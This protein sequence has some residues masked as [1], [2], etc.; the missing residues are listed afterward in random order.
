MIFNCIM[1][2]GFV[3]CFLFCV[4]NL[5]NDVTGQ[6]ADRR[7]SSSSQRSAISSSPQA[8]HGGL[9]TSDFLILSSPLSLYQH[10]TRLFNQ[11]EEEV[12]FIMLTAVVPVEIIRWNS[13]VSTFTTSRY[14]HCY[15]RASHDLNVWIISLSATGCLSSRSSSLRSSAGDASV[16]S[17]LCSPQDWRLWSRPGPRGCSC[18]TPGSSTGCPA[19]AHHLQ[20]PGF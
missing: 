5:T 3:W 13:L 4:C 8:Y 15:S 1:L 2:L 6:I 14:E 20:T 16:R 19:S 17:C 12:C 11:T 9:G 18:D 7:C 10:N